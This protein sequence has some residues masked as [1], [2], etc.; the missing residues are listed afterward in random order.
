[1]TVAAIKEYVGVP[2]DVVANFH[3]N[4]LI[5]VCWDGH[6]MYAAPS[7]F[8]VAPGMKFEDF[9]TQLLVPVIQGHPD[10]AKID[11]RKTIWEKADKPWTPAFEKTVAEN[12]IVHK[13]YLRFK[14][15]GLNGYKGLGI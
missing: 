15:P 3:G 5:Y 7:I 12:G 11:W 2:L 9:L 1:M 10:T 8:M 4:Q 14:T 6:L 13:E